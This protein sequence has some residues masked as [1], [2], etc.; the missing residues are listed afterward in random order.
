MMTQPA[1]RRRLRAALAALC[2]AAPIWA[3]SV[4]HAQATPPDWWVDIE[5]DR[6]DKIRSELAQGVD[7]NLKASNGQ[8]ALLRA[9]ASDSWKAF[10]A[11]LADPRTD[12]N[13]ENPMGETP[14]M[15]V[16][17]AGDTARAQALLAR[18]AQ[19]NKLGWTPLHYAVSKGQLDMA[20]L[21]LA[22]DAMPNAPAPDGITP[23]M[24]AAYAGSRPAVQLLLTAGADPLVQ[25][26]K[27]QDAADWARQGKAY[28]LSDELHTLIAQR[29]QT[30]RQ[31]GQD[32]PVQTLPAQA[33]APAAPVPQAEAPAKTEPAEGGTNYVKGL[34]NVQLNKY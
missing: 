31:T 11:L 10:D 16:A 29:L 6:A 22:R 3:G 18:G 4:A 9:V 13:A 26:A 17:I 30:R 33:P 27:N 2:L 7:P 28:A 34:S 19:V 5:N 14:L 1:F 20:K 32:A 8:P 24:M 25:D 15:Y 21:L 12:V 23:L